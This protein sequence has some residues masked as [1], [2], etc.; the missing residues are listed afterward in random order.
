M[1]QTDT[2]TVLTHPHSEPLNMGGLQ[3]EK[4]LEIPC[5][6]P[7]IH[8]IEAGRPKEPESDVLEGTVSILC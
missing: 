1:A 7:M 8:R 4:G 5:A 2:G 6:P 3:V